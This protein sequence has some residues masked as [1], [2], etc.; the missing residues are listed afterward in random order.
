MQSNLNGKLKNI[1]QIKSGKRPERKSN[2]Q[3]SL[4]NILLLVQV[5]SWATRINIYIIKQF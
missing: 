4:I 2:T 1:T 3:S 5:K